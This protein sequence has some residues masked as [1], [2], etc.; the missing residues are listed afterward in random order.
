MMYCMIMKLAALVLVLI[1]IYSMN[2][3]GEGD[4]NN[5][6]TWVTRR[7]SADIYY[8]RG[9]KSHSV[10]NDSTTFMVEE[11]KC[12]KNEEIFNG[13]YIL[14]NCRSMHTCLWYQ[15]VLIIVCLHI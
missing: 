14:S 8:Q 4:I 12:M 15:V 3:Y 9:N 11:R 2:C 7:M 5:V 6:P 10:C 1:V 13:K